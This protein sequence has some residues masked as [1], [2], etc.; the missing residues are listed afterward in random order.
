MFCKSLLKKVSDT[1]DVGGRRTVQFKAALPP[2]DW[3]KARS[4]GLWDLLDVRPAFLVL[5]HTWAH[6]FYLS[7]L[8]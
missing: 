8:K 6:E 3:G 5:R 7:L 4:L 1:V 2:V